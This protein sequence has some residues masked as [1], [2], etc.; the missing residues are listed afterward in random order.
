[1]GFTY[2]KVSVYHPTEW[3]REKEVELLVDTG[4]MMSVIPRQVLAEVKIKPV[5]K[6]RLRAFGG[7][8]IERDVGHVGIKVEDTRGGALVAFGK[9]GDTPV[10]GVPVLE[11]MGYQVDPV[12]GKLKK[13]D[14]LMI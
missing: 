10:L 1:M 13:V 14:I 11:S 9:E 3:E 2:I 4:A 12:T 8:V 5:A 7:G 6:Q